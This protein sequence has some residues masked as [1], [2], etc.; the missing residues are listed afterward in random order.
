MPDPLQQ[1]QERLISL[2]Q[3]LSNQTLVTSS[4]P[5][6]S[7]KC[8]KCPKTLTGGNVALCTECD[9]AVAEELK[10]REARD[11]A[12]SLSRRM[13]ES[14]LPRE[15]RNG[16]RTVHSIPMSGADALS[17]CQM[18]GQGVRG[19]YLYGTAGSYKTTAAAAWLAT[20]IKGGGSGRYV[21]VP[22]LLTDLYAVYAGNGGSR[23]DIV[24]RLALARHLVLDDL[25]K[26]KASEHA[27]GVI[28][29]ILDGRY[30][31]YRQGDWMIVT[32]NYPLNEL[33]DRFPVEIGE[34]IRRRLAEMTVAVPM[35]KR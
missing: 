11:R 12:E 27:A 31:N 5:I 26:E 15:Y 18:L 19:L 9:A 24:D 6:M 7:G 16:S 35:G 1:A 29:E 30:R 25:G 14:G 23:A 3:S 22:D 32:S 21:F 13:N 4:F 33:C 34:P 10:A 17:A 2:R 20:E 8:L 28:F